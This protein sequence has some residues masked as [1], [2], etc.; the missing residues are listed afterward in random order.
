MEMS[1]DLEQERQLVEKA[2]YNIDAF[3]TLY[4]IYY[5]GIFGYI[6]HRTANV[7]DAQDIT[8]QTFLKA[9]NNIKQFKWRGISFSSWLYR[10]ASNEI[11]DQYRIRK[12]RHDCSREFF[13]LMDI[14]SSSV[15]NDVIQAEEELKRHQDYLRV[16]AKIAGLPVKYQEVIALRFFENKDILEICEI[17]GK[18]EGTVKSLLH[19]GLEKLRKALEEMQ[20]FN[21]DVVIFSGETQ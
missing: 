4:D 17:L 13:K 10:I 5:S 1:M 9:L 12:K 16:Q 18:P 20:P 6:L 11:A 14:K 3:G 15:E 2:K 21:E 19:R 8:S 7:E